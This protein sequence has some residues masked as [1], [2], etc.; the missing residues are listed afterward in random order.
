MHREIHLINWHIIFFLQRF[1]FKLRV[2]CSVVLT[3][4]WMSSRLSK[5]LLYLLFH[6]FVEI[7]LFVV[8]LKLVT[9]VELRNT[10]IRRSEPQTFLGNKLILRLSRTFQAER[11]NK[12]KCLFIRVNF[13]LPIKLAQEQYDV[14]LDR[15]LEWWILSHN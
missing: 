12:K 13:A 4:S 2:A 10:N 15:S 8:E 7:K 9:V 11:Q 5:I 1:K 14:N 6:L 3:M